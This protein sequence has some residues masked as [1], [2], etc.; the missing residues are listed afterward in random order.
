[1]SHKGVANL[2][3]PT[4]KSCLLSLQNGIHSPFPPFLTA[5]CVS[6]CIA[7]C[8]SFC[9]SLCIYIKAHLFRRLSQLNKKSNPIDG[10]ESFVCALPCASQQLMFLLPLFHLPLSLLLSLLPLLYIKLVIIVKR[11]KGILIK[12][13]IYLI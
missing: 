1:M 9:I 11:L 4:V 7:F 2:N 3:C 13:Y 5:I 8:I 12:N 6:L 10:I